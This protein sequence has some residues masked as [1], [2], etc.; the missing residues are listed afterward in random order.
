MLQSVRWHRSAQGFARNETRKFGL[1]MYPDAAAAISAAG[2]SDSPVCILYFDA[3]T[4]ACERYLVG[5]PGTLIYAV[6]AN[7]HPAVLA[8][9]WAAGVRNFDVASLSEAQFISDSFPGARLHFMHPVKSPN[10][11]AESYRLGIRDFA[12][13]SQDELDKILAATARAADLNLHLRMSLSDDTAAYDLSGKFGAGLEAGAELLRLAR[14]L[15]A[16]LGVTFHVGSQSM[17]PMA[18]DRAIGRLRQL[19]GA[20]SVTIDVIDV[21]G[22]FPIDYPGL[23][24]LPP[25]AYFRA[26]REALQRTGLDGCEIYG[27]PGRALV[28]AGGSTLARVELRR[29]NDLYLNDGV[30][31]TLFDAGLSGWRYPVRMIRPTS[32]AITEFQA[33]RLFGPTCDSLDKME[34][35][36]PLPADIAAGSWIEIGALGAYGQALASRFN[37]FTADIT[38]GVAG[39]PW[40][41][42]TTV[43]AAAGENLS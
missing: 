19:V 14:P 15:A 43:A 5:F 38:V 18:Y 26:I 37:G 41:E 10:A 17:D 31:G 27:E 25:E 11:I 24:P 23:Q 34:G 33:F 20:A 21:G 13:D 35:P 30:Y 8:A 3:I 32:P 40:F 39:R 2:I 1:T 16:H 4:A 36:F 42:N 6:K 29:G 22:G 7:P 12:F 28:A 9:V